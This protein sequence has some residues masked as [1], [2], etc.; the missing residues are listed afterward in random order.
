M[1]C[2]VQTHLPRGLRFPVPLDKG[3]EGSGD[4]IASDSAYLKTFRRRAIK[5]SLE[6]LGKPERELK[7][8]QYDAIREI[9]S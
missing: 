3:N 6:K 4:E 5:F 9:C 2:R 7:R 1:K 8:K